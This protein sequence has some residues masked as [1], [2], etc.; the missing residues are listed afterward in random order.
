M[1]IFD[2]GRTDTYPTGYLVVDRRLTTAG[3]TVAVILADGRSVTLPR[4]HDRHAYSRPDDSLALFQSMRRDLAL[5]LVVGSAAS[6][7]PRLDVSLR[8]FSRVT[9]VAAAACGVQP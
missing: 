6:G 3:V 2:P 5:T 9:D 8:G 4:G 7:E 1:W